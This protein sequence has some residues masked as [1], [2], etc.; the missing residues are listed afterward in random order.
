M[1]LIMAAKDNPAFEI[2]P[3]KIEPAPEQSPAPLRHQ[4]AYFDLTK[5]DNPLSVP[6]FE[7]V[8]R[9]SPEPTD[10][11]PAPLHHY[12]DFSQRD[13][14]FSQDN[15]ST[16]QENL[17]QSSTEDDKEPIYPKNDQDSPKGFCHYS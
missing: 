17:S 3:E 6:V 11:K 13:H 7:T 15:P 1:F 2:N 14:Y 9:K 8:S 5:L 16:S 12:L 4:E 10:P